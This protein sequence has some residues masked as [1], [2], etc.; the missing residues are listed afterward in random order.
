MTEVTFF[1]AALT[2]PLSFG[3]VAGTVLVTHPVLWLLLSIACTASRF[4]FSPTLPAPASRPGMSKK[5]GEDTVGT[6]GQN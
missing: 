6:A 2:V 4:H 3:F 1:M 5:L